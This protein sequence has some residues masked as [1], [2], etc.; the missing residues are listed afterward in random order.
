MVLLIRS[1]RLDDLMS[2]GRESSVLNYIPLLGP[3]VAVV[4]T[5]FFAATRFESLRR[6]ALDCD[7]LRRQQPKAPVRPGGKRLN[8]EVGGE[9]IGRAHD[10]RRR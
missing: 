7:P 10:R 6:L 2:G 1:V 8:I 3:L 9:V 4:L 5:T